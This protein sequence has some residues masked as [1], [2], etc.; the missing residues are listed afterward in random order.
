MARQI[1]Q[2]LPDPPPQYDQQYI[3]ALARSINSFMGQ[4]TALAE[5]TAGHF[6]MTDPL[7]IPGVGTP[8]NGPPSTA[9]LP[10]GLVYLKQIPAVTSATYGIG[11][12]API[13][14]TSW[15][16]AGINLTFTAPGTQ[17]KFTIDGQVGNT[18]NNGE[19]DLNLVYGTGTPP[20]FGAPVP[21]GAT[22]VGQPV[23]YV[24]TSGG[25]S[26]A[27][28]SRTVQITGLT[29]GV[30]YWL[31]LAVKVVTGSSILTELGVSAFS[32]ADSPGYFLTVVEETDV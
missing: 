1:R 3:A 22:L 4:A 18:V 31:G 24:A 2:T 21:A 12:V 29:P 13:S 17:V 15:V 28:F 10:N 30:T 7:H 32:L 14:S 23:R 9:K 11:S 6:I 16:M 20:A 27:P 26:F 19:T 8:P 25:G 5:V